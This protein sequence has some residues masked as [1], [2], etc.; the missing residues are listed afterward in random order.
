MYSE[1]GWFPTPIFVSQK[2]VTWPSDRQTTDASHW[3]ESKGAQQTNSF[4]ILPVTSVNHEVY[5]LWFSFSTLP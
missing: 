4:S 5:G 1:C 3:I 2:N